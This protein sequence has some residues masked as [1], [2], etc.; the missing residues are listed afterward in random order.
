MPSQDRYELRVVHCPESSCGYAVSHRA[1]TE[2][3]HDPLCPRCHGHRL[4]DFVDNHRPAVIADHGE[5][6]HELA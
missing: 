6:L 2:V 3:D 1:A 5:R 4:G